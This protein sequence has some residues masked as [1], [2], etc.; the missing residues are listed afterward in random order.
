MAVEF[1]AKEN[2]HIKTKMLVCKGDM[3]NDDI[4]HISLLPLSQDDIITRCKFVND[5]F[6]LP[7]H[8]LKHE[9]VDNLDGYNSNSFN[10]DSMDPNLDVMP[11]TS[12]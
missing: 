11:V 12:F 8:G 4:V 1:I 10:P 7:T 2:L 9:V 5:D 6:N 3:A